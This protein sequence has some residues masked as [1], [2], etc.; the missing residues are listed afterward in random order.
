V[1]SAGILT[2]LLP[3]AVDDELY[4][5]AREGEDFSYRIPVQPG[6]YSIRLKF[7]E[8]ETAYYFERPMTVEINGH[9][10]LQDF[11]IL[12]TMRGFGNVCDRIF[13]YQMP[14]CDGC[15]RLRFR[16]LT[17][18][19]K[20]DVKAL[21]RAIEILP[22]SRPEIRI[23]CGSAHPFIDW[24]TDEW[25]ADGAVSGITLSK[26]ATVKLA[27]PTIWDQA[28]YRTAR[29]GREIVYSIPLPPGHYCVQMKFAELQL[30]APGER[31]M[32]IFINGLAVKTGW[33]P[34]AAAGEIGMA[35][36]IRVEDIAPDC[37]GFL[38]IRLVAAGANDAMLQALEIR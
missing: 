20:K 2:G 36:G 25:L 6:L 9:P 17:T 3:T 15:I 8:T 21:V 18:P 1:R 26:S 5:T 27:T 24:N 12:Q 7:A 34:A 31:P 38:T 13:H 32:D 35:T 29:Q 22:E 33:D 37:N 28:L 11:D 4:R 10:V 30:S 19:L 14:D 23:N 16:G